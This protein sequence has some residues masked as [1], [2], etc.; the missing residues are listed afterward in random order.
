MSRYMYPQTDAHTHMRTRPWTP[1]V[2]ATGQMIMFGLQPARGAVPGGV[3]T[4]SLQE[5]RLS[6]A[7]VLQ[8][9]AI[10]CEDT[11]TRSHSVQHALTKGRII[12]IYTDAKPYSMFT[13]GN[14]SLIW[15]RSPLCFREKTDRHLAGRATG[16]HYLNFRELGQLMI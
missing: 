7:Y 10:A 6:D 13:N 4:R 8:T 3:G 2:L 12:I 15:Y 16:D 14:C 11:L 9:I 1:L 5:V